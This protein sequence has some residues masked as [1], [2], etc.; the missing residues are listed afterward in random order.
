MNKVW[1]FPD[2]SM[3]GLG[4]STMTH[5]VRNLSPDK[6]WKV[7]ISEHKPDRSAVQNRLYWVYVTIIGAAL[8][9]SKDETHE[10]FKLRH[11]VPIMLRDDEHFNTLWERVMKAA[12]NGVVKSFVGLLSTRILSKTQF[13]EYLKDI[14]L[15]AISLSI[16]LPSKDDE[17]YEAMGQ[18][19]K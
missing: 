11:L 12:D 8:G 9:Y 15:F 18:R 2:T 16:T 1:Y 17:Y 7:V 14:E 4:L 10:V 19:V 13:S 3:S 6:K 5:Y